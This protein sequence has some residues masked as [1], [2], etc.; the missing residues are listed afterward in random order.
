MKLLPIKP[1]LSSVLT[2]FNFWNILTQVSNYGFMSNNH[3]TKFLDQIIFVASIHKALS[4]SLVKR[5]LILL[6]SESKLSFLFASKFR[7]CV[8]LIHG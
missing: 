4:T 1:D 8:K 6:C 3:S 7:V 5:K 2:N